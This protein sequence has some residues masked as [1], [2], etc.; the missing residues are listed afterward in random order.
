M[1]V[2]TE[3]ASQTSAFGDIVSGLLRLRKEQGGLYRRI[4]RELPGSPKVGASK[5]LDGAKRMLASFATVGFP[6]AM[7]ND[8]ILH[9][10][11]LGDD[12]LLDERQL[13]KLYTQAAADP[14]SENARL[15]LRKIAEARVKAAEDALWKYT[16]KIA[17]GQ[18]READPL[19]EWTMLRLKIARSIVYEPASTGGGDVDGT[20]P[21]CSLAVPR[22]TLGAVARQ[23]LRVLASCNEASSL[24]LQLRVDGRTASQ[25][26]LSQGKPV[27]VGSGSGRLTSA[28][29]TTVVARLT[30]RAKAAFMRAREVKVSA[31]MSAIDG[32]GNATSA[33]R[34]V[35]LRRR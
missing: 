7:A 11:L 12:G 4:A 17:E 34:A 1:T 19:I 27:T 32:A 23:G 16:D 8:A 31:H 30:P 2:M 35:T 21:R 29:T 33:T 13:V 5:K 26:G 3:N 6:R 25:L 15:Y 18:W 24:A 20:A 9:G 14:P 28:G 10:L 22:Q